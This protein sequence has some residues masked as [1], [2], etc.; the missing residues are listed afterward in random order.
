MGA[1][2]ILSRQSE[3]FLNGRR[4][5]DAVGAGAAGA[6]NRLHPGAFARSQGLPSS[7]VFSPRKIAWSSSCAWPRCCTLEA[8]NAFLEQE[9]WPEWNPRFARPLADF[10]N[11]HRA[12]T[13]QLDLAATL[14]HVEERVIAIDY[15]QPPVSDRARRGPGKHAPATS[16]RRNS[17]GWRV[18]RTLSRQVSEHQPVW[19]YAQIEDPA[20]RKPPRHDHNAG[21][22]ARSQ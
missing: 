8:A 13:P 12:L 20:P 1:E 11:Q 4:S 14:C 10:P 22:K 16:A 9:Y 6:G 15:T 5:P 3:K 21:G 7:A 17:S 18:V 19:S 2:F